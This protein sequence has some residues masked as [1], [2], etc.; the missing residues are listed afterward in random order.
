MDGERWGVR[1]GA[2]ETGAVDQCEIVK[3]GRK[4]LAIMPPCTT[5]TEDTSEEA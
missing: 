2:H 4:G 5:G 1:H 3:A